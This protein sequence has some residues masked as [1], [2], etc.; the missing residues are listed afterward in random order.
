[1][2]VMPRHQIVLE[3]HHFGDSM[4]KHIKKNEF[5][6]SMSSWQTMAYEEV[7]GKE[8]K[9]EEDEQEEE[10]E[11]EEEEEYREMGET[12]M[13]K[14]HKGELHEWKERKDKL[15]KVSSRNVHMMRILYDV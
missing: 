4:E 5:A 11:E 10:E 12:R 15:G 9:E 6:E 2:V 13:G 7:G 3:R 1:M 8:E 14:K